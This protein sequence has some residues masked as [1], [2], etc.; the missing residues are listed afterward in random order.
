M[1]QD[2]K[3]ES[4]QIKIFGLKKKS[5]SNRGSRYLP[6]AVLSIDGKTYDFELKTGSKV[7]FSTARGMD[8]QKIVDW[9]KNDFFI[10][11]KYENDKR[12]KE[13]FR[14]TKHIVCKPDNLEFFFNH[15]IDKVNVSGHAGKVGFDEYTEIVR[16][17]LENHLSN[18]FLNRMD[19]TA[20]VGTEYNDPKIN[21][22]SIIQNGGEV[23]DLGKD[24]KKQL[25]K[26]IKNNTWQPNA[27][28]L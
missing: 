6:D 28:Q 14:F 17:L 2:D 20:K 16:P 19:K 26:Y 8:R 1:A 21:T 22:N 15:V 11:S 4:E 5:N 18:D 7:S 23:L 12:E 24:L 13:G 10:F 27:F 9:K 25:I 3:R